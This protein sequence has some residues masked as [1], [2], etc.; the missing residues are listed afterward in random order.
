[1]ATKGKSTTIVRVKKYRGQNVFRH[2]DMRSMH[3]LPAQ[4]ITSFETFARRKGVAG[5]GW[6]LKFSAQEIE[7]IRQKGRLLPTSF[8]S[9]DSLVVK[10][11]PKTF[12]AL[13][14]PTHQT[15]IFTKP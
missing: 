11:H 10:V 5:D 9:G 6:G 1:M 4:I 15:L 3:A 8:D 7:D 2:S 13:L 14:I 12:R